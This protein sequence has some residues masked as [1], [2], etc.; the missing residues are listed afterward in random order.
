[1]ID[2]GE[3]NESSRS[4][5]TIHGRPRADIPG[6]PDYF[7]GLWRVEAEMICYRD[8]TFCG[9]YK[10][11]KNS[12]ACIIKLLPEVQE[13]ADKFGLPIAQYAEKPNCH[14]DNDAGG[15]GDE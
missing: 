9:F 15:C 10:D 1:L 3:Q 4:R 11:C 7:S 5:S 13:D 14:S 6:G 8:R 2:W 12:K